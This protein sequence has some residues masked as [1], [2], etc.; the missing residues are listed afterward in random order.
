MYITSLYIH[1]LI[2]IFWIG[3]MLFTVAVLVPATRSRLAAHKGILFNELG[4]RFSRLS[5]I[6][7]PVL[8]FTG[9]LALIGRGYPLDSMA[10]LDFWKTI[11]GGKIFAKI[12]LFSTVILISAVHDFWLGPKAAQIMESE[13]ISGKQTSQ[14]FYRHASRWVGR[15]NFVLGLI[16]LYYALT[17]VR[18]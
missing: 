16:I 4:T 6:L 10:S 7:F 1:V 11:Y 9:V 2:A 8:V 15:V 3:G 5:W 18:G 17:L 13:E 12:H 14:N